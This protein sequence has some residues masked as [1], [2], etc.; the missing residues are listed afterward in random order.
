MQPRRRRRRRVLDRRPRRRER[1]RAARRAR[2]R[3]SRS[4]ATTAAP[5]TSSSRLARASSSVS[6]ST[7]S[8]FVSATTPRSMPSSRRIARCSCVCG[9]APS[10]ASITS[11]KR[12]M[13]R[14]ARRPSCARSARGRDVDDA[15]AACRREARAARSRGRSRSRAAAPPAAGRCSCR[16]APRRAYVLPWSM[17]P[18][19]PT[20]SGMRLD[21]PSM[22]DG[23]Q[24]RSSSARHCASSRSRP[25]RARASSRSSHF[26]PSTRCRTTRRP[27]RMHGR[28][29]ARCRQRR[30]IAAGS[31]SQ[32]WRIREDVASP[33]GRARRSAVDELAVRERASSRTSP[34]V[35]DYPSVGDALS[36]RRSEP[37]P[38][39]TSTTVSPPRHRRQAP[40]PV[41]APGALDDHGAGATTRVGAVD[42]RTA[43][44]LRRARRRRPAEQC[45]NVAPAGSRSSSDAACCGRRLLLGEDAVAR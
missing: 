25:P 19:V 40:R 1:A 41:P 26:A 8:A 24:P 5:G 6:S 22:L 2:R 31:S 32:S 29:D 45:A 18:A 43:F 7:T 38:P 21:Q 37:L 27:D 28:C 17:C 15:R 33:S 20:V 34:E 12:S 16:S 35:E 13:P 30:R 3:S 9:R 44:A 14:R 23:S 10:R 42:R 11:R 36:S 4:T 39:P